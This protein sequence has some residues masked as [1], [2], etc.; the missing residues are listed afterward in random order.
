MAVAHLNEKY[1]RNDHVNS[2]LICFSKK[3]ETYCS[4][5]QMKSIYANDGSTAGISDEA[6]AQDRQRL[7]LER[8]T[9]DLRGKLTKDLHASKAT[10]MRIINVN[11]AVRIEAFVGHV[12]VCCVI[13]ENVMLLHELNNLREELK[14]VRDRV[15]DFETA[16]QTST[17]RGIHNVEALIQTLN[18]DSGGLNDC[19]D[20]FVICRVYTFMFHRSLYCSTST[21]I[22]DQRSRQ[23]SKRN[24][25]TST[26][27]FSSTMHNEHV[28]SIY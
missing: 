1:V 4:R 21:T 20:G 7:F 22:V 11:R 14:I 13:Q 15:E 9:A 26:T 3:N 25:T 23:K 10:R 6:V 24:R 17:V 5:I 16:R 12:A 19:L 18:A 28:R 2:L 8:T 27:S